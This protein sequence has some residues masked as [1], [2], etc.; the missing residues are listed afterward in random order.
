MSDLDAQEGNGF[1]EGTGGESTHA[2]PDVVPESEHLSGEVRSD[3][4]LSGDSTAK[5]RAGSRFPLMVF[6]IGVFAA[7]RNGFEKLAASKW[8]GWWPFWQ[9]EKRLERLIEEADANPKDAAKQSELL[10]ELNKHRFYCQLTF[11]L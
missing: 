1:L 4:H 10:A 6:M 7:L 8:L 3:E 11:N 9:Q 2:V 5:R